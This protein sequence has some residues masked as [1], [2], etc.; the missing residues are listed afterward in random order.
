MQ[1]TCNKGFDK[2]LIYS[3]LTRISRLYIT[4]NLPKLYIPINSLLQLKS[5]TVTKLEIEKLPNR[6]S[7]N[8]SIFFFLKDSVLFVFTPT[9]KLMDFPSCLSLINKTF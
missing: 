2:D 6:V 8:R 7:T 5:I 4:Y 3:K 1:N 9:S